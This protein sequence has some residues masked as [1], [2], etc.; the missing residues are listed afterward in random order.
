MNK[1]FLQF[2]DSALKSGLL[3]GNPGLAHQVK[4]VTKSFIA[5]ANSAAEGSEGDD[6]GSEPMVDAVTEEQ[7]ASSRREATKERQPQA[8]PIQ[9][10]HMNIG[11]GYSVPPKHTAS[12]PLTKDHR[13]HVD[14]FQDDLNTAEEAGLVRYRPQVTIGHLMDQGGQSWSESATEDANTPQMLPFGLIDVLSRRQYSA[15]G[16]QTQN[17]YS[18]S[19][20]TPDVSPPYTRLPTPPLLSLKSLTPSWT[21]SHDETTFARRLTRAS[22]EA[23]FR[24]LSIANQRPSALNH[25]FRL[26]LP[27]MTLD[28]IRD[29]FKTLLARGVDE[30]LNCWDTPFIHLGGAGTHYQRRD[31]NGNVIKIPNGWTIRRIGP[32]VSNLVRAENVADPSQSQDLNIDLTGLDGEWFDAWDVEGYLEHEKGVRID[33]KASFA[34]VSIDDVVDESVFGEKANQFDYSRSRRSIQSETPS[35]GTATDSTSPSTTPPHSAPLTKSNNTDD[36]FGQSDAPFGLD[37]GVVGNNNFTPTDF[38]KFPDIDPS[39]FFDQPLGLDLAP[40]FDLPFNLN[41]HNT[42]PPINYDN[43]GMDISSLGLEMLGTE[44]LRIPVVRQ[45]KKK[46]AWVDVSKLIDSKWS[47]NASDGVCKKLTWGIAIIS[48]GVC[49]GRAPGFRRKDID[50]AFDAAL[51]TSF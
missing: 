51:I 30:D 8:T 6:D 41:Q 31:E 29:R 28:E 9:H 17:I 42:L 24:I 16:N 23:G 40:G 46:A 47:F 11:W 36:L 26:S 19:I 4:Q 43:D 1:S 5:L 33:P 15:P 14:S 22:L 35:F 27:F 12:N 25:V 20:P 13:R 18:V 49:L 32:M 45:K 44:S 21:Y 39:T 38:S 10:Q 3:T 34:E 2:N 50:M 37:M 7:S 48:H